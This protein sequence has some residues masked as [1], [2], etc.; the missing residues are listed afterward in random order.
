MKYL[1]T[2][3][4]ENTVEVEAS[5]PGEAQEIALEVGDDLP[6]VWYDVVCAPVY[7]LRDIVEIEDR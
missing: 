1:V 2:I 6:S 7:S 3:Y 5:S 4:S